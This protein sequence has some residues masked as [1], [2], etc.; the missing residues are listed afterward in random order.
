[1][2][3]RLSARC[4]TGEPSPCLLDQVAAL[5]WVRENII[6]FGGGPGNVTIFGES[7]GAMSGGTLPPDISEC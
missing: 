1:M 5:E 6:A 3:D 4:P 7:A 2:T